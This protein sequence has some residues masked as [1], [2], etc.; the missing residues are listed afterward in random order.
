MFKFFLWDQVVSF[1]KFKKYQERGFI[2][3]L[4]ILKFVCLVIDGVSVMIG[5]EVGDVVVE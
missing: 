4:K 1:S 2:K 5:C 3:G